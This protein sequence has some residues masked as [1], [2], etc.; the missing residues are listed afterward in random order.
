MPIFAVEARDKKGNELRK[1]IQA[2]SKEEA[3]N[4]IRSMGYYPIKIKPKK[5]GDKKKKEKKGG[6]GDAL[7]ARQAAAAATPKKKGFMIGGVSQKQ[8]TQFTQQLSI[9]Q[10]AGLPIVRSL[11]ILE[12]QLKP[13]PL[14][15]VL[16]EVA[17]EVESG[18]SLSEAL[19]KH[20]KVFDKLFVNM[21]KA[22]EAGGVLDTI[23]ERLA[24]F[25]EKSLKLKKKVVGA[26]IYPI[27][28]ITI[29]V[30]IL[31][32]IMVF[33]IPSF[34]KMFDEQGVKLP[35]ITQLL[36]SI[37]EIVK[38]WWLVLLVGIPTFFIATYKLINRT[39]SGKLFM[40]RLKLNIPIFGMILKKSTISRFCRTLGTLIASGVPILEALS[41]VKEAIGNEV[42]KRAIDDVYTSIKEGESIAAPLKQSGV[43]DDL[44]VNMID[45]GEE[46]GE[47]DKM[48]MKI[49]D[50]YDDD[51]DVAVESMTSLMEPILIIGMGA[52]VGFIVI[53][54]FMPLVSL[55]SKL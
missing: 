17:D 45:V 16:E 33:V 53:A 11:R 42:I 27:A 4:K 35:A 37:S 21:V 52:T 30:L 40:D 34:K 12:G 28:V 2:A 20:P 24:V 1:E 54:L 36:L 6:G 18:S 23:L 25:Q 46:T 38:K 48:L 55:I 47:L 39:P 13:C 22:G 49:A 51:V 9:L 7:S 29:A 19:S 41:I 10:D 26:M 8:L 43:F 44:V 31:S 5:S 32:G 3:I 15:F 14:K 50:T